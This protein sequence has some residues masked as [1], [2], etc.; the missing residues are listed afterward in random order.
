M[1]GGARRVKTTLAYVAVML[2]F[3]AGYNT[4]ANNAYE[5]IKRVGCDYLTH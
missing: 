4:G 1:F 5:I 2:A 3:M